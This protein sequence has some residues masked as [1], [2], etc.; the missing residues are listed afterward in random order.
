MKLPI[1]AIPQLSGT[2]S[3]PTFPC[4]VVKLSFDVRWSAWHIPVVSLDDSHVRWSTSTSCRSDRADMIGQSRPQVWN[5][6]YWPLWDNHVVLE[7]QGHSF[8]GRMVSP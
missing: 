6:R 7:G 2:V 4:P 1:P 3:H 8:V 5:A